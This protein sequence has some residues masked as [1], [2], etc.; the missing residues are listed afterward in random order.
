[1]KVKTIEKKIQKLMLKRNGG[2]VRIDRY[3]ESYGESYKD[4]LYSLD[5][6][7]GWK[8]ADDSIEQ[9]GISI[10]NDN[11]K[12]LIAVA[13][14]KL[15]DLLD[16]FNSIAV[17]EQEVI[18]ALIARE[19]LITLHLI[20]NGNWKRIYEAI[21]NKDFIDDELVAQYKEE[22]DYDSFIT[23]LDSKYPER[24]K[25]EYRPVFVMTEG[26]LRTI[27]GIYE[28]ID[29][30]DKERDEIEEQLYAVENKFNAAYEML[31]KVM[32]TNEED[33]VSDS[34]TNQPKHFR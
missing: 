5:I 28:Q 31:Y 7:A 6:Y 33:D 24:L 17:L 32:R 4:V 18:M 20:H 8:N 21:Q 30:L 22:F 12:Q 23:I 2:Y 25:H 27:T 13:A 11:L 26:M 14:F 1:M 34:Y 10:V 29:Q 3:Q 16:D 19:I 15:D 9:V